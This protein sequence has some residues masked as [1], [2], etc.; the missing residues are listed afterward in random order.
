MIKSLAY[1]PLQC[2]LNSGPVINA[3][4]DSAVAS[5]IQ[6]QENSMTADAAVIWSVLWH[7]RMQ[8]NRAVYEHYRS[9]GKPVIIVEVGTLYRGQTWRIA[10]NHITS[11]GYYGQH[12]NLDWDRPRRLGVSLAI[13]INP[14]PEIVIAAQHPR[15]LQTAAIP[16][17]EKWVYETIQQLRTATDRPIV[18]RP[19]PRARLLL[20]RLPPDVRLIQPQKIT[21]TYDSYDMHYRCHAVVNYNSGPGSQ[22]AIAGCRPIVDRSSLAAPVAVSIADIEKPYDIDRSQWLV[23]LC[24]TEYT[25]DE[26]AQGQWLK[27]LSP[28]LQVQ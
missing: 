23:E 24:H 11:A 27:R 12:E 13:Q 2:A 10:V 3:L 22:A 1:F 15:S 8:P 21:N 14:T 19:H 20:P 17:M 4:L 25:V 5:G 28:S 9:Q 7:G 16:D 18:V 26:I 6:L